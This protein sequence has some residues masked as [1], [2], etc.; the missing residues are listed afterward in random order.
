VREIGQLPCK[1]F[2]QHFSASAVQ[3]VEAVGVV[4]VGVVAA[5]LLADGNVAVLVTAVALKEKA[6]FRNLWRIHRKNS[7]WLCLNVRIMRFFL[8]PYVFVGMFI[9]HPSFLLK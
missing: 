2:A 9:F 4:R 3:E 5:G 7:S 1:I 6:F 8:C